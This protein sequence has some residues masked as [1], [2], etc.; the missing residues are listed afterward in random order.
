MSHVT[1]LTSAV[2]GQVGLLPVGMRCEL[3]EQPRGFSP[4]YPGPTRCS[5]SAWFQTQPQN[6][7][8]PCCRISCPSDLRTWLGSGD[9]LMIPLSF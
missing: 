7:V 3:P 4:V 1:F 6:E 9:S 5:S 8:L 2:F